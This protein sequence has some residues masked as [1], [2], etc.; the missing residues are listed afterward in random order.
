MMALPFAIFCVVI[1]AGRKE[2]GWRGIAIFLAIWVALLSA[3]MALKIDGHFFI[4]GQAILDVVLI[5]TVYL[6]FTRLR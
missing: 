6:G 4:A 1:L 2:L 3:V 5:S